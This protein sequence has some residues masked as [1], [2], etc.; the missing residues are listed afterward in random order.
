[1][2]RARLVIPSRA[3]GSC[4]IAAPFRE[5]KVADQNGQPVKG[6]EPGEL[7]VRGHCLRHLS[8]I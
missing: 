2:R 1:M 5:L 3:S 4:G 6:G 7:M 8:S